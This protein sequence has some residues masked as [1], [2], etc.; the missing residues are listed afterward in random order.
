M[1]ENAPCKPR[2]LGGYKG[3]DKKRPLTGK[4]HSVSEELHILQSRRF[5]VTL[6]M[7]ILMIAVLAMVSS[8]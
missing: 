7:S 5:P 2:Q 3:L 4:P 8:A 1:T 6:S